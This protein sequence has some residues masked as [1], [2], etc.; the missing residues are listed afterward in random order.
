ML[1]WKLWPLASASKLPTN[2]ESELRET[3]A[4]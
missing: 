3:V 2:A 4:R 1:N